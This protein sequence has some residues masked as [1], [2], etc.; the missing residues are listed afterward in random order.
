MDVFNIDGGPTN[1]MICIRKGSMSQAS[2][3][4]NVLDIP[5]YPYCWYDQDG[6]T[7]ACGNGVVQCVIGNGYL[8]FFH[9]R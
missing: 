3:C 7:V 8:T 6:E 5:T 2:N 1:E 4:N 9:T